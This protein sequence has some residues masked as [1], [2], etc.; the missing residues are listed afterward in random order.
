MSASQRSAT[1]I[2]SADETMPANVRSAG[3]R[4]FALRDGVWTDMGAAATDARLVRV[5]PFAELYFAL[6]REIPELREILA[7]GERVLVH[8][9][10]VTVELL[11]EGAARLGAAEVDAIARD[12]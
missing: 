4:T 6:M 12:W 11:P 7:L 9:R 2:S 8:G 10:R 3:G 1:T 5:Q